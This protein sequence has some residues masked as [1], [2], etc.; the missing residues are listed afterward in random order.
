MKYGRGHR[1]QEVAYGCIRGGEFSL[2][3]G[4]PWNNARETGKSW[5]V[6]EV[7]W[8]APCEPAKIVGVAINY[9]GATG[10]LPDMTEPLVFLKPAAAV[11]G[12]G[13]P[14]TCGF[15]DIKV[16]GE[17]ELA[18]I[19]GR[20]L[21]KASADEARRAIF[22]YTIANDVTADNIHG[23]DHHLARAKGA[24]TFCPIG[25]FIETDF[26]PE[27]AMIRGFHNGVLLREGRGDERHWNDV[28]LL[29]AI[30][31]WMTLDPGDVLLTGTPKRVRGRQYLE[32]GDIYTCTIDSLGELANPFST[33]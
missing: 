25:P 27:S 32:D 1:G 26:R 9:F 16:W 33:E 29:Q 13:A 31:A 11:I 3:D 18:I 12:P 20:R 17:S 19:I 14:I 6:A 23:W 10:E 30:S 7:Q 24:D 28:E 21:T 8:L 22:G 15:G 4:A 5:P 2:L